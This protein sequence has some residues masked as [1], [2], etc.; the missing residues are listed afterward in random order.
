MKFDLTCKKFYYYHIDS[1]TTQWEKPK[2]G[3]FGEDV[4][5]KEI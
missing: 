2:R 5:A 1:L 3:S 4:L